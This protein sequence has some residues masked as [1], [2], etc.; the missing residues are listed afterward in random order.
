MFTVRTRA[1]ARCTLYTAA[2]GATPAAGVS[3]GDFP[4]GCDDVARWALKGPGPKPPRVPCTALCVGCLKTVPRVHKKGARSVPG[5][6]ATPRGG[7]LCIKCIA[8]RPRC[9]LAN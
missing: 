2:T 3:T 6:M 4:G 7:V 1:G 8:Q 5:V 9:Y